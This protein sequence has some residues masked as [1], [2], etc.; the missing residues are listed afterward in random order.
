MLLYGTAKSDY[1][2]ATFTPEGGGRGG[3]QKN[4]HA[5]LIKIG[6]I[7]LKN[8][9]CFLRNCF[10]RPPGGGVMVL[11][12]CRKTPDKELPPQGAPSRGLPPI[13]RGLGLHLPKGFP[14]NP[15][16]FFRSTVRGD[17]SE[18]KKHLNIPGKKCDL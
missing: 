10:F 14:L 13:A 7:D 11:V 15:F 16:R 8:S 1:L 2:V 6:S 17:I 4:D 12:T 5:F 9:L 18:Q 3:G